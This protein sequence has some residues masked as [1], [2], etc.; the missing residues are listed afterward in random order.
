ME[1]YVL[2]IANK[3]QEIRFGKPK[4]VRILQFAELKTWAFWRAVLAEFVGTLLF[5][6]LGVASTVPIDGPQSTIKVCNIYFS[7]I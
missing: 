6:F 7:K 4:E 1:A 3:L 5:V 2:Y